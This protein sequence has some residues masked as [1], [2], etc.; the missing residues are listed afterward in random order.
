M[1]NEIKVVMTLVTKQAI[2]ALAK[3]DR[4]IDSTGKKAVKSG[5]GI[6]ISFNAIAVAATAASTAITALAIKSINEFRE[7]EKATIGVAK[8]TT[9]SAKEIDNLVSSFKGLSSEIPVSAT[10][11]LGIAQIAGQLGIEGSDNIEKFTRVVAELGF[12]T[13]LSSEQAATA[14]ARLINVTTTGIEDV[15]KLSS[16]LV[17]LGNTTAATES[18][19]IGVA[20]EIG[21]STSVFKLSGED[22]LGLAATLKELGQQAQLGG[23]VVGRIFRE[24]QGAISKGGDQ[25]K[26][27]QKITGQTGESLKDTFGRDTNAVFIQFVSGLR[28]LQEEGVPAQVSLERF[29]LTGDEINKVLPL[30]ARNFAKLSKNL[31]RSRT[32]FDEN[33]ARAK[34]AEA[35]FKSLDAQIKTMT[36]SASNLASTFGTILAPA[37]SV[38]V[39]GLTDFFNSIDNSIKGITDLDKNLEL[40]EEQ[41]AEVNRQIELNNRLQANG[42]PEGRDS[43]RK[44]ELLREEGRLLKEN[45]ADFQSQIF[46]QKAL[47]GQVSETP[48][49]LKVETKLEDGTVDKLFTDLDKDISGRQQFVTVDAIPKDQETPKP[50]D[51]PDLRDQARIDKEKQ[52]QSDI[53]QLREEGAL[54]E[55]E[56]QLLLKETNE[57]LTEAELEGLRD[58]EAQKIQI[59]A[60]AEL[61]KADLIKD[62]REKKLQQEKIEA[63]KDLNLS[64][65]RSKQ[66]LDV[67]ILK[68]KTDLANQQA[69]FSA[70]TSLSNS[71]NSK[72]AA[73][74][75]AAA[76]TQIA[77]KTPPAIASSF[78]FGTSTGGPIL[79]AVLAGIAGIAMAAQAAKIA[80]VS[81]Q[82]GGVVPGPRSDFDNVNANLAG[83]EL[84]LNRRQ[85]QNLFDRINADDLGG[86]GGGVTV[87]IDGGFIGNDDGI[88]SLIEAISNRQEF[89]NARSLG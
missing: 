81:L 48:L 34:E 85:Q 77:I 78:A 17:G 29:G 5:K 41:Y 58:I 71:E 24:I 39:G 68:N 3:F 89:G 9:L 13:D 36:N 23:S 27:L 2:Q 4:A 30:L 40:L 10:E 82:T 74:G 63:K 45:I 87:N 60:D 38:V 11:L 67:N 65:L 12:A 15:D 28:R 22:V 21:K 51:A 53:Q 61:R 79:G 57:E 25:F 66:S 64:K 1:A 16:A 80:G 31:A 88:D 54:L 75:K 84:I 32:D 72:L 8:T 44:N 55:E 86:G 43:E 59:V 26:E 62:T 56:R 46:A 52:L 7:L 70:A 14:L 69:F 33:T 47:T 83:G 73:V 20:Q 35:A 6:S 50:D 19:I 42:A 49:V 76:I 18:E 37:V